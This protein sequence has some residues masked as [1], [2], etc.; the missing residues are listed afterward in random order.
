MKPAPFEYS[1]PTEL[2]EALSLLAQHGDDAKILAGGQSLMPMMNM[3]LATP[4]VVND[5]NRVGGLDHLTPS[6]DG[7]LTI[8][9]LARQRQIDPQ[10]LELGGQLDQLVDGLLQS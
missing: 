1:A 5:V 3:R 9:A 8:G 2:S 10:R 4:Q 7:G 6:A